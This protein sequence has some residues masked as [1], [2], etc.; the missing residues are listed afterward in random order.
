VHAGGLDGRTNV[1]GF[2]TDVGALS[3]DALNG[4]WLNGGYLNGG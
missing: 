1:S 4:T 2:D 3:G